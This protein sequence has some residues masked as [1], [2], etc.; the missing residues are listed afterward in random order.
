MELPGAYASVLDRYVAELASAP[1]SAQTRRTYAS[2]VRQFLTWLAGAEVDSDPI[3][4]AAVTGRC[5]TTAVSC[6]AC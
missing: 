2:K 5:A 6:R 4:S 1:L 3:G